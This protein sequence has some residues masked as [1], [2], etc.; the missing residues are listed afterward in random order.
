[1]RYKEI[2][3]FARMLRRN[4]TPAEDFF[5]GKVRSKRLLGLKFNR[6]FVIRDAIILGKSHYYIAD[7]H[8]FALKLIVEIDGPIHNK[9]VEYDQ[10]R[11]E[12]LRS[13]GYHIIRFSNQQV[14]EEWPKVESVLIEKIR[15]LEY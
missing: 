8:C 5:W 9:Q 10:L 2:L 1:M 7:F 15:E 3:A 11:E 13:M 4:Q 14:I 6:Q 12:H